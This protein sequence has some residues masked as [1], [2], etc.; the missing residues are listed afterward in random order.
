MSWYVLIATFTLAY[1][2]TLANVKADAPARSG[3]WMQAEIVRNWLTYKEAEQLVG[4]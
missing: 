1:S 2:T 3:G 4:L